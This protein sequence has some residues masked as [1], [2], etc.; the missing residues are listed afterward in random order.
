MLEFDMAELHL[1]SKNPSKS[2]LQNNWAWIRDGFDKSNDIRKECLFKL[3]LPLLD[4]ENKNFGTLWLVK[5]LRRDAISHYT[6]R[7]VEHLRRTLVGTLEKLSADPPAT[8]R[9]ARHRKA[10]AEADGHERAGYAD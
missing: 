8:A 7:R 4:N 9:P 6:L 1:N 2:E 5:D 10:S 3:E